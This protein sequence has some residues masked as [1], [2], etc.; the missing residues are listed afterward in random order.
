MTVQEAILL[1]IFDDRAE[2]GLGDVA[3]PGGLVDGAALVGFQNIGEMFCVHGYPRLP[4]TD[5]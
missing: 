2:V 4:K 1:H 3:V 5:D